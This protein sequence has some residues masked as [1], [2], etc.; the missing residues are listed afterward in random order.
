MN[1]ASMDYRVANS[2]EGK[3][4]DGQVVALG[5]GLY[6][7]FNPNVPDL[8][9][10]YESGGVYGDSAMKEAV[11]PDKGGATWA[12]VLPGPEEPQ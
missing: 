6:T 2:F 7:P 3:L 10:Y 8:N 5:L 1:V 11:L 9:S 4:V 12:G